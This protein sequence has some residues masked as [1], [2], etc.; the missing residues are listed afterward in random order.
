MI[1]SR[2]DTAL[3]PQ[4]LRRKRIVDPI[5]R[6]LRQHASVSQHDEPGAKPVARLRISAGSSLAQM[7]AKALT[8]ATS[9]V[10]GL[11]LLPVT[12]LP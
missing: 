7:R 8:A 10:A 3:P 4:L 5:E 6:V 9:G 12:T 2:T 11:P 1:F